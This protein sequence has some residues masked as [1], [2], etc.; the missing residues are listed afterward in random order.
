MNNFPFIDGDRI[1]LRSLS[2]DDLGGGYVNWLNDI[3]VCAYNSHHV[4]PYNSNKA[5]EYIKSVMSSRDS[6]V[7]AVVAKESQIHIG[8]I[9]LQK[10]D[11]IHRN[12]EFAILFGEK[13]FWGKGLAK[14]AS[15]LI[16]EHGF[17]EM[18]LHRIYCGT[19][20]HNLAMQKLALSLGMSEEGRRKEALFKHGEYADLIE[21]GLTKQKFINSK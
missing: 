1:L 4:F 9:S 7:L 19:S 11:W 10:I 17:V 12:A 14:E 3:E 2:L 8:N 13:S 16:I 6:L 21:Y 20:E 5:E 18:N 15:L